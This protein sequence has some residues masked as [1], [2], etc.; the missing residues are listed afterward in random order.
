MGDLTWLTTL[1]P[2]GLLALT[3]GMVLLGWL[4]PRWV[5]ARER[6]ISAAWERLY[7][8]EA[9]RADAAVEIA[10]QQM[11]LAREQADLTRQLVAA[12]GYGPPVATVMG[13]HHRAG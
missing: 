2:S 9:T 6:Q 11:A 7:R 4:V 13:R 8:E 10:K 1:G 5:L 3:V 12:V